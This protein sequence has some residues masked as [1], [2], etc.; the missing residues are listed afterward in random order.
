MRHPICVFIVFAVAAQ[1]KRGS[2]FLSRPPP[3]LTKT[4]QTYLSNHNN[5]TVDLRG[6]KL[7][8]SESDVAPPCITVIARYDSHSHK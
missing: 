5:N 3:P 4:P 1:S 8:S 2:R 7:R 6:G